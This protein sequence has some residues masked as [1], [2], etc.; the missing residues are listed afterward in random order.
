MMIM[1]FVLV[2]WKYTLENL[3]QQDIQVRN[4][5]KWSHSIMLVD[6]ALET[7]QRKT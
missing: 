7:Y 4:S 5:A 6:F 3:I 1:F 2:G